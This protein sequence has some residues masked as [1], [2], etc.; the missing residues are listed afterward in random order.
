MNKWLS[1]SPRIATAHHKHSGILKQLNYYS[2]HLNLSV[3]NEPFKLQ[4]QL[5]YKLLQ[6]SSNVIV[7]ACQVFHDDQVG[8]HTSKLQFQLQHPN[9]NCI[10]IANVYVRTVL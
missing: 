1:Q 6:K 3:A 5:Q 8:L 10:N 7:M 2:Q 9:L 4:I